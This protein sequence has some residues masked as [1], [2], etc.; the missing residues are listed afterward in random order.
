MKPLY[1]LRR[2]N[3]ESN[4][5]SKVLTH[6]GGLMYQKAMKVLYLHGASETKEKVVV[7]KATG[8]RL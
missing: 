8:L 4:L 5:Q 1:L 7:A 3:I 6:K 2:Q